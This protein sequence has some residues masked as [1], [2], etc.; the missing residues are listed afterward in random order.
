MNSFTNKKWLFVK[1]LKLYAG[2]RK[3]ILRS[4]TVEKKRPAQLPG[5]YHYY[6]YHAQGYSSLI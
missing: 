1:K 4:K 2:V 5:Q 6:F 3:H